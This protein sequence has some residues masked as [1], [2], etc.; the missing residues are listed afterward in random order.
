MYGKDIEN[1]L[2]AIEEVKKSTLTAIDSLAHETAHQLLTPR[3]GEHQHFGGTHSSTGSGEHQ[4]D[5]G[6]HHH[7]E[8]EIYTHPPVIESGKL[9]TEIDKLRKIQ[10]KLYVQADKLNNSIGSPYTEIYTLG[11]LISRAQSLTANLSYVGGKAAT[12]ANLNAV[13][14]ATVDAKYAVILYQ[15]GLQRGYDSIYNDGKPSIT[16]DDFAN[17]KKGK[18]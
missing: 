17:D 9:T 5:S 18:G 7:T 16:W 2:Q 15:D 13:V 12:L 8:L 4:H 11:Q 10:S 6:L 3:L 14:T 1:L